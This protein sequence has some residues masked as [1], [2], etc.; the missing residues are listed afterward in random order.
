M[1]RLVVAGARRTASEDAYRVGLTRP[2]W[3][4]PGGVA[5]AEGPARRT[6]GRVVSPTARAARPAAPDSRARCGGGAERAARERGGPGR[7]DADLYPETPFRW[8]CGR[9]TGDPHCRTT[10]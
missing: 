6:G 3:H 8:H 10:E 7:C 5:T 1:V 2:A 4:R 9:V